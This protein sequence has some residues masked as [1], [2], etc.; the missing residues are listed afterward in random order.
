MFDQWEW[1]VVQQV[2]FVP[3]R[4]VQAHD[5]GS[6]GAWRAPTFGEKVGRTRDARPVPYEGRTCETDPDV[7][8]TPNRTCMS[9]TAYIVVRIMVASRPPGRLCRA[10]TGGRGRSDPPFSVPG[11]APGG[12]GMCTSIPPSA[13][14]APSQQSRAGRP[15]GEP[16]RARPGLGRPTDPPPPRSGAQIRTP[17]RRRE[18]RAEWMSILGDPCGPQVTRERSGTRGNALWAEHGRTPVAHHSQRPADWTCPAFTNGWFLGSMASEWSA[19]PWRRGAAGSDPRSGGGSP[20]VRTRVGKRSAAARSGAGTFWSRAGA[21]I[22]TDTRRASGPRAPTAPGKSSVGC[23]TRPVANPVPFK[24]TATMVARAATT[25][26]WAATGGQ[27]ATP[28]PAQST[29]AR[30]FQGSKG[31]S[32]SPAPVYYTG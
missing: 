11:M 9:T 32:P 26:G 24:R 23:G 15:N 14:V 7:R 1:E 28:P 21:R 30:G 25:S 20:G 16:G 19:S 3:T 22:S 31:R 12:F 4:T 13:G 2:R 6:E 5:R 8:E 27:G 10:E 17:E 29:G 18:R